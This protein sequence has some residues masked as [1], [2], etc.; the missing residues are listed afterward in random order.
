MQYNAVEMEVMSK[1]FDAYLPNPEHQEPIEEVIRI[2]PEKLFG[3]AFMGIEQA[4][5]SLAAQ[6]ID[7]K[8]RMNI[9]VFFQTSILHYHSSPI[10]ASSPMPQSD[11]LSLGGRSSEATFKLLS[12]VGLLL[13][14]PGP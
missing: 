6:V 12:L 9:M 11:S 5:A 1:S 4:T 14:P 8:V 3:L 7:L 10:L 2:L 13:K